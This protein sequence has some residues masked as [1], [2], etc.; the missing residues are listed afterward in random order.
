M[1]SKNRGGNFGFLATSTPIS[2]PFGKVINQGKNR[3]RPTK[4]LVITHD[5]WVKRES[6]RKFLNSESENAFGVIGT[7]K[8]TFSA[9]FH[10]ENPFSLSLL[11]CRYEIAFLQSIQSLLRSNSNSF[12]APNIGA[13]FG[14]TPQKVSEVIFY[15]NML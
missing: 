4:N 2:F 15:G 11:Y 14:K 1:G 13:V 12:P 5:S 6:K 9:D 3:T 8:D 10:S 7:D